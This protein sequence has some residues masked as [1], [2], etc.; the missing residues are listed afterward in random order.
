[1]DK[2]LASCWTLNLS[3]FFSLTCRS[4]DNNC[5]IRSKLCSEILESYFG[6]EHEGGEGKLLGASE[7]SFLPKRSRCGCK[8]EMKSILILHIYYDYET[9]FI[10]S[11]SK[12]FC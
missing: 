2:S 12:A 3:N 5:D 7:L 6:I 11:N 8:A 4:I 1:M 9:I 10:H